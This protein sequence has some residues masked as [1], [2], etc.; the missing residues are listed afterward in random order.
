MLGKKGHPSPIE[1]AD[2]IDRFLQGSVTPYEWDDFESLQGKTPE[3]ESI[4]QRV[5]AISQSHP[6]RQGFSEW[7]S[8]SGIE[9]LRALANEIRA[10]PSKGRT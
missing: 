7:S 2:L 9:A 6:P 3:L 5:I 1:T 8:P 4:R 10:N